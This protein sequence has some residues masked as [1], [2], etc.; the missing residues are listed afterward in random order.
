MD[1]LHKKEMDQFRADLKDMKS[2]SESQ[3]DK[4]IITVSSGAIGV[5]LAF[6]KDIQELSFHADLILLK[7][8]LIAFSL[9][10]A[11]NLISHYTAIKVVEYENKGDEV[12][13]DNYNSWTRRFNNISIGC[14]IIGI[15]VL[16]FFFCYIL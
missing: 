14:V 15:V 3:F 2:Y 11:S 8:S 10:I 9:A 5:T 16:V 4:L 6:V 1:D 12:R 7:I 13:S